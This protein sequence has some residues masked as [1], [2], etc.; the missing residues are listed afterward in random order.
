[1]LKLVRDKN[2]GQDI[3]IRKSLYP[4][5]RPKIVSNREFISKTRRDSEILQYFLNSD[6][7]AKQTKP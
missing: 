3:V 7:G 4:N 6:K 1:M 2:T 5:G